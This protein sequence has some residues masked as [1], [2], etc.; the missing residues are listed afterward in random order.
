MSGL[1]KSHEVVRRGRLLKP[2]AAVVALHALLLSVTK[3]VMPPR[4]AD[5][6]GW[7][8]S[9][10]CAWMLGV[11][12]RERRTS[13]LGF[14][15]AALSL[16]VFATTYVGYLLKRHTG[17]SGDLSPWNAFIMKFGLL[18]MPYWLVTFAP[19]S[20]SARLCRRFIGSS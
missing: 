3:T 13:D 1:A 17:G 14:V 15:T 10:L 9:F 6:A 12:L 18:P 19:A 5:A 16:C 11:P 2:V 20:T 4:Q 8:A 7:A